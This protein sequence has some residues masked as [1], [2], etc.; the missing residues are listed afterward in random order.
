MPSPSMP[1]SSAHLTVGRAALARHALTLQ[2]LVLPI[3][4]VVS[5]TGCTPI[6]VGGA[7]AGATTTIHDRRPY[8]TV[9]DDQHIELA[10]LHALAQEPSVQGYSQ[11]S[12]TSYNR[13]V[14]LTGQAESTVVAQ[15]A[16]DLV[17]RVPKVARVV[18]EI[19]IGA[20]TTLTR[21]S[22]DTYI[23]S[24]AKLALTK[25]ALPG[26]DPTRVKIVT[27]DAVVYL[28]GLVSPEEADAAVEQVRYV[29]GVA[30]V[31]K[32][33]EYNASGT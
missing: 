10:V 31:V 18:D 4:L 17:S 28:M 11:I 2:L 20:P 12:A 29:P 23:T 16:S 8:Y 14:L 15:R 7:F 22:Q 21:A 25:V 3:M 24:R 33:F 32:L 13:T 9:I 5:L 6:V 27:E 26:F 30:Q 1:S 19:T